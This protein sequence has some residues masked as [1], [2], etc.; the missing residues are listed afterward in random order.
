MAALVANIRAGDASIATY[1]EFLAKSADQM[2]AILADV[3]ADAVPSESTDALCHIANLVSLLAA[4]PVLRDPA[5]Y[6]QHVDSLAMARDLNMLDSLS[7]KLVFQI[8]MLTV[9]ARLNR[10]LAQ[11]RTGY[12]VP[13]H[14][15]FDDEIPSY[16]DRVRILKFLSWSPRTIRYGMVDASTGLIYRYSRS[17]LGRIGMLLAVVALVVFISICVLWTASLTWIPGWPFR[18][19]D[20]PQLLGLWL[21]LLAGIVVHVAVGTGKRMQSQSELPPPLPIGDLARLTSA[22]FG[23]IMFKILLALIGLY[24]S[25]LLTG[26]GT[27]TTFQAFLIGYSLDSVIE[28]FGMSMEQRST[29]QITTLKQQLGVR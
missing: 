8:G 29:A 6:G 25:L 21:A 19:E 24:G 23:Q 1:A 17:S 4:N 11:A 3:Q 16:D 14:E 7:T 13:F 9:P 15:V 22:R 2:D 10:W 28:L 27:M 26:L 18:P 12:Y 20:G 5:G